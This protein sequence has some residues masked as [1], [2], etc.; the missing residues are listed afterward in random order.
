M[1][2]GDVLEVIADCPTFEKD[3]RD[4][5]SRAKKDPLVGQGRGDGKEST[6][7][8]LIVQYFQLPGKD[9]TTLSTANSSCGKTSKDP[10]CVHKTASRATG[11]NPCFLLR[12]C[13]GR[14]RERVAGGSASP[15]P[16]HE[17][18]VCLVPAEHVERG[19]HGGGTSGK[20]GDAV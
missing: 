18:G 15:H 2:P 6:D 11:R 20:G 10:R 4:W 1:K 7:P 12:I 3:V 13:S 19:G 8:V 16:Y 14:E 5:C 17:R 9:V